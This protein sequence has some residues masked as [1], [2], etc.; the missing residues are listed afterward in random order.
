[1]KPDF[2]SNVDTFGSLGTTVFPQ[3]KE[4]T[5]TPVQ[6]LVSVSATGDSSLFI[7]KFKPQSAN[8]LIVQKKKIQELKDWLICATADDVPQVFFVYYSKI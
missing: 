7:N 2:G 8:E 5:Q 1:M 6:K 3:M 4:K